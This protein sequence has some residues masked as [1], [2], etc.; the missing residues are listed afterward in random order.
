MGKKKGCFIL[1]VDLM[2]QRPPDLPSFLLSKRIIYLAM[3]IIPKVTELIIA[4]LLYLQFDDEKKKI[5][6]YINST[7]AIPNETK[8]DNFGN[9][10]GNFSIFDSLKYI[11]P[12]I[13]SLA[14]GSAWGEA[15]I[16]LGSGEPGFRSALPS[17]S[18]MLRQFIQ[19]NTQKQASDLNI[20]RLHGRSINKEIIKILSKQT[21]NSKSKI[22]KT[23]LKPRYFTPEEAVEFGIIDKVLVTN[24]TMN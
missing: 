9:E 10:S 21:G 14:I 13:H 8:H 16:L 19:T 4:E 22:L 7:G 5:C 17:A 24:R 12:K 3:P 6:F 23:I 20:Y 15:A 2:I 11:K 18:I 1:L